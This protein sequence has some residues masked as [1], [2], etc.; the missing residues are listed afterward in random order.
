M[1][2]I[3]I[4]L[5]KAV[6]IRRELDLRIGA[7]FTRFQTM[8]IQRAV[9]QIGSD[10]VS[11]GSCQIPTLGFIVDRYFEIKNFVP[12]NFWYI[13]VTDKV[14]DEKMIFHWKRVRLFNKRSCDAIYLKMMNNLT[15]NVI[16]VQSKPT[17]KY[18][19]TPMDTICLEKL[20]SSKLKI[21]AKK[22]MAAAEKLYS[23]GIISYPR[24]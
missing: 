14:N 4:I 3:I 7:A 15:A 19:P 6:D 21:S 22:A 20:A 12:E 8:N 9:R 13:F 17:T 1:I 10:L 18:R 11:Y 24:T 23:K 2:I 16:S 5:I